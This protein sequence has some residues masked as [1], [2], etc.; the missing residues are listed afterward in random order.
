[1][2]SFTTASYMIQSINPH[3]ST[4][5][6]ATVSFEAEVTGAKSEFVIAWAHKDRQFLGDIEHYSL[7]ANNNTVLTRNDALPPHAG[8]YFALVKCAFEDFFASYTVFSLD[9]HGI[10]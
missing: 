6:G 9:I 1:M 2:C 5:A 4:C 10:C 8:M 7:S 3:E